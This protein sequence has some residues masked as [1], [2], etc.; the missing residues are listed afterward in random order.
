MS[1]RPRAPT[2]RAGLVERPLD[3][4]GDGFHW[5]ERRWIRAL[6]GGRGRPLG[7]VVLLIALAVVVGP[8]ARAVRALRLA[9][10]DGYQLRMPRVPVSA[11]AVVVQ[12]D[13]VSL[14]RHGQW[15]W[16]RTL[17]AELVETIA[18]GG[19]R[20]IGLDLLMPEP[21]RLSPHRL[22]EIVPGIAP[23][24][25]ERLAR[26]PGNDRALALA[27]RAAPT[28]LGVAGID[29]EAAL[30]RPGRRPPMR[31]TGGDPTAAVRSY[32][33]ELR[34]LDIIDAAA[35][36]HGLLSVDVERGVVRQVPVVAS[37]SGVLLPGFG[38]ELIRVAVGAPGY[39]VRAGRAG[40]EA[41]A[42]ANVVIPTQPDGTVWIRYASHDDDRFVS[43]SDVLSGRV[44]PAR[45]SRKIVLIG[46]TALGVG[47]YRATPVAERMPGVEVHAQLIENIFDDQT[48]S[49]P[50]WMAWLEAAVLAAAGVALIAA[51]PARRALVSGALAALLALAVVALGL[52][53][54]L[55]A[56]MLF[57]VALPAMGIGG[58]F[59]AMLGTTLADVDAQRRALRR[60]VAREREAAARLAGELEAARRIQLGSLPTPAAAFPGEKRFDL[61]ARL[62]PAREVGG[63]LYDFF[64]LDADR[65]CLLVG[66][67]SG[68]GLAGCLFM[69]VSKSLFKSV[70]LRRGRD[71]GLVLREVDR[72]VG[73][74]NAESFFVT[75]WAAILN[76][77]TGEIEY[78]SAGHDAPYLLG[79]AGGHA[80]R[81]AQDGGPPLCVVEGFEYR[82]ARAQLRRG[83]MLC[84]VTDG[85]TEATSAEG[86]LYG[87]A[88]LEALLS[89]LGPEAG[90]EDV[91]E[92]IRRDVSRFAAGEAPA[93]DLAIVVLRWNGP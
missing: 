80:G 48:L 70:A 5:L 73:R 62:E 3:H 39:V 78:E 43:A 61:Y 27:L 55:K 76:V 36:G 10:F 89:T 53:L 59:T 15:P 86:E 1:V 65:I 16:P 92:A 30:V 52:A 18:R 23:D 54:Y 57:D 71:I 6:R 66:D 31:F 41:V 88:R 12:V 83:Q 21:D 17:L 29:D 35:V 82:A 74:D 81:L 85:V 44:A 24:L 11:P 60:Q 58:L 34:S 77:G 69:T 87:R 79:P 26:L 28:V 45:F 13:E 46:V 75:V 37:V 8:E 93:D 40:V 68:K 22:P 50:R 14:A 49:R 42:M 47:D 4:E 64:R 2:K 67:V 9:V 51:V 38:V 56:R 7:A 63:D 72:E 32:P 33:A 20:A 19:P 91:G 25:A 84:L 90:P